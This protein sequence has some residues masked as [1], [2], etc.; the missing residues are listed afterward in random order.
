LTIIRP[1]TL[2]RWHRAGLAA[3][4]ACEELLPLRE[5]D[6]RSIG[7]GVSRSIMRRHCSTRNGAAEFA[8]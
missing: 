8:T 4:R 3:S 5:F 6:R 1:E 2:V 7:Y